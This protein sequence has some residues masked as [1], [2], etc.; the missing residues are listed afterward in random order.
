MAR[1]TK[2]EMRNELRTIFL[3]EADH[4][5]MGAGPN[6]ARQF[7]GFDTG[8]AY[9]YC[10]LSPETV[11][12]SRFQIAESFERGYDF[13]FCPSVL[14]TIGEHE[15]QNLITFMLGTPRAGGISSGGETHK[16]MTPDGLCQRVADTVHARWKLEW[17]PVGA[18]GHTFTTRE[19][20]LLADMTEGAVRNA[21]A[22]KSENG[23]QAVPG[24]KN[25]VIIEHAEAHRWLLGRR[26]FIPWPDRPSSDRFLTEH[27][28]NIQS[29]EALGQLIR[30]RINAAFGTTQNAEDKLGWAQ[31]ILSQWIAGTQI[32][33]EKRARALAEALDFEAPLFVGKTLEVTLRRDLCQSQGG[34]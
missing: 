31:T 8:D 33:D 23:L 9:E 3:F 26:G 24:T 29:S 10:H 21:L 32:F 16:F 1:F 12:L 27:L 4:I 17:D 25:P 18:G 6:V 11:D 15:V 22:D 28:Q 14:N 30:Q 20:A 13:A 34:E 7:I 5:L 19:L 2:D